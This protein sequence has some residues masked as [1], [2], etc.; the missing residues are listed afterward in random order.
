MCETGSNANI[1][2]KAAEKLPTK[3]HVLMLTGTFK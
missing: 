2:A 3:L 1:I